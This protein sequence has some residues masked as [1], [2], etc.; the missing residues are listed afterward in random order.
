MRLKLVYQAVH[1]VTSKRHSLRITDVI[2]RVPAVDG[3]KGAY[4]FS[5]GLDQA[6]ETHARVNVLGL[7]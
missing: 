1:E 6:A 2:I 4:G 5:A 3:T 7:N